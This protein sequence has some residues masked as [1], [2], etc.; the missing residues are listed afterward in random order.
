MGSLLPQP[1]AGWSVK[2]GRFDAPHWAFRREGGGDPAPRSRCVTAPQEIYFKV[3]RK[4]M[5]AFRS[6]F[7]TADSENDGIFGVTG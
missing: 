4:E 7:E 3:C 6:A 2:S 1:G 5:I